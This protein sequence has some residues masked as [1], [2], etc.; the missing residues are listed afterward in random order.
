MFKEVFLVYCIFTLT[1]C[2]SATLQENLQS[3]MQDALVNGINMSL[4]RLKEE[5]QQKIRELKAETMSCVINGSCSSILKKIEVSQY[6]LIE[7]FLNMK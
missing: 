2:Q 3:A 7:I 1:V 5:Y 4:N 6:Y